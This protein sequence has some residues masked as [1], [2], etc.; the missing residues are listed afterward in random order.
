MKK[1]TPA[2][3]LVTVL[4]IIV[5]DVWVIFALGRTESISAHI[6]GLGEIIPAIPFALGY[7]MGHLTWSM[8]PKYWSG[9]YT[10]EIK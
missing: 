1:Y 10:K 7:V 3:I 2:F 8:K 5:Y 9:K 6:L 4:S